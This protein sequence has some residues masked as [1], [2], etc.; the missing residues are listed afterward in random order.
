VSSADSL[1][2]IVVCAYNRP[3]HLSRTLDS[4]AR[5]PLAAKSRLITF[6]DGPADEDQVA[7]VREVRRVLHAAR[8][9][10]RLEI[11]ERPENLGLAR[12]VIEGV[13]EVLGSW[14]AAIVLED[15]LLV[16]PRFLEVLGALLRRYED[17]PRVFSVTGYSYPNRLVRIPRDYAFSVYFGQRA[18]S[19]GWGTWRDR[20]AAVDWEVRDFAEFLADRQS[21]RKFERGGADLTGLLAAQMEGRVDSWA[22]RFCYASFR[23]GAVHAFPVR[24]LVTNTGLDGSGVHCTADDRLADTLDPAFPTS[25]VLPERIELDRRILGQ[26]RQIFARD[27]W[28]RA[29]LR[30]R[31]LV[32]GARSA[33][34]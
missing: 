26:V 33:G 27:P 6:S 19:W 11:V 13:G 22:V 16:S 14:P 24:T 34:R 25:L 21:R 5:D 4:L 10:G 20:W 18:S 12:S 3:G 31:R 8:G 17:E 15:D 7:P 28:S 2:T 1:P 9:F 29:R 23:R 30:L 32:A